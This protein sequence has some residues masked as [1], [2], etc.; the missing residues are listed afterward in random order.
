M[1]SNR[2]RQLR[3]QAG[4]SGGHLAAQIGVD[5]STISRWE[6]HISGIPDWRKQQVAEFFGVSVPYLMGWSDGHDGHNG[7]HEA[8]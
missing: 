1:P 5:P 8:A 2:L 4:L 6:T 7:E 3:L